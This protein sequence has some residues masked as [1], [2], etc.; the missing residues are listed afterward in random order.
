M[1][2]RHVLTAYADELAQSLSASVPRLQREKL[3]LLALL[4]R[5]SDDSAAAN[6]ALERAA[7]FE[8]LDTRSACPDCWIRGNG[9][10]ELR[11]VPGEGDIT[12]LK[13]MGCGSRFEALA[14][15][16]GLVSRGGSQ[17]VRA[18]RH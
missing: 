3:Q 5:N 6:A 1:P 12:R 14:A 7:T 8:A 10:T 2:I 11:P 17:A 13:C 16:G 4:E 18:G 15:D 9:T